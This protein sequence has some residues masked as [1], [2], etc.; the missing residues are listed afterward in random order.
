MRKKS[1]PSAGAPRPPHRIVPVGDTCL[2]VEFGRVIDAATSAS[3]AAMFDHLKAH[4]IEGVFDVVP[5]FTTLALH[6]DPRRFAGGPSPFDDLANKV[7]DILSL[8]LD[9][10][11]RPH[12]TVEIPVCYGGEYGPDVEPIAA[13]VGLKPEEVIRLHAGS[14][15]HVLM[16]GFAPGHPYAG[17]VDA[18]LNVPRRAT[19]RTVVAAGSVAIANGLTIIYPMLMPGGW[20]IVGRTPL[21]LFDPEAPVP[22]LLGVGDRLKFIPIS[23]A[24]FRRL[25]GCA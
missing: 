12:R 13:T 2:L 1:A 24:E 14:D 16:V 15:T 3:I 21:R 22:C 20:N 5:A 10:D 17:P 25:E 18:R 11:A 4:P 19:P 6:Y 8:R 7:R 9:A 23:E